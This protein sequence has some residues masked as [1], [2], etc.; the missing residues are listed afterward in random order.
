MHICISG[1]PF[2]LFLFFLLY[3][4]FREN[5]GIHIVP[6]ILLLQFVT[7]GK[8]GIIYLF[9]INVWRFNIMNNIIILKKTI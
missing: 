2:H 7:R 6:C 9:W 4:I 1:Q 8:P 3:S 5:T